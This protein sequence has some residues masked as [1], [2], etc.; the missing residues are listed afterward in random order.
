MYNT[1]GVIRYLSLPSGSV[2]MGIIYDNA[3]KK[4]WVA[5]CMNES[6]A[7]I[8]VLTKTVTI[9]PLPHQIDENWYGP[10]PMTLTVTPDGNIWFS[11]NSFKNGPAHYSQI[12]C[13][14]KL[15]LTSNTVYIYYIP[16]ALG[17]A[18]YVKFYKN[19]IWLL[20]LYSL[21]KINYTTVSI[22]SYPGNFGGYMKPDGDYL[23]ITVCKDDGFVVRFN[24]NT[25]TFDLNI[26]GF[27]RPY[28]IET[29]NQNVYVAERK[30]YNPDM[31]EPQWGTI[32]IVNKA[33]LQVTRV[34]VAKIIYDGPVSV[35]KD[36]FGY[37]WFTDN[38][39][40]I[41]IVGGIVYGNEMPNCYVPPYCYF[42]VEVPVV[43]GRQIWFSA[44]GSAHVG[45]KDTGTLGRTD[46]NLDGKVDMKD[47]GTVA[48]YFG[49]LVPPAPSE[50]DINSDGKVD[51]RDVGA[52]AR[53]F[54]KM[55]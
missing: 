50:C 24:I 19:Y 29:D 36:S 39:G 53:N 10:M 33:T 25:R 55:L 7:S 17:G 44:V 48:R 40:H 11:I 5:L 18:W 21:A 47:V 3:T 30:M 23:W 28:G 22:E 20:T 26:T 31:P 4:V 9:Y 45:V 34:N 38:S 6:I 1:S 51:M 41:G 27:D 54:G 52:V 37:L 14:G 46:I 12:P 49:Q 16:V 2:P 43:G 42:M 8:D 35:L 13:L 32:A 15:D